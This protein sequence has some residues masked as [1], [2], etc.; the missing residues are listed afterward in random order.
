MTAAA[1]PGE[2]T[3]AEVVGAFGQLLHDAGVPVT[4][5]RRGRFAGGPGSKGDALRLTEKLG[6]DRSDLHSY[7]GHGSLAAQGVLLTW[8]SVMHGGIVVNRDGQRFDDETCG[9]SEYAA[10]VLAQPDRVAWVIYDERVHEL[11]S[12]FYDYQELLRLPGAARHRRRPLGRRR[13]GPRCDHRDRP[14]GPPGLAR[15]GPGLRC[16]GD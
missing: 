7:Q 13:R 11:V 4:P 3:M 16:R 5:E 6:A 9:Y 8:T 14:R 1:G 2:V 12:S 10:K 15:P